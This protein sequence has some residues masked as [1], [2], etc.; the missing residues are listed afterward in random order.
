MNRRIA[1]SAGPRRDGATYPTSPADAAGQPG[2]PCE[3]ATSTA[4][5]HGA[6]PPPAG[7]LTHAQAACP[8]SPA[9][10]LA[11]AA[12]ASGPSW[13]LRVQGAGRG[14]TLAAVGY[15]NPSDRSQPLRP[16]YVTAARAR[17]GILASWSTSPAF[18]AGRIIGPILE[19]TRSTPA[20]KYGLS[21]R[22]I[23]LGSPSPRQGQDREQ[24]G[25][26]A[27]TDRM[28]VCAHDGTVVIRNRPRARGTCER[29][30]ASAAR[31]SAAAD[32][33]NA[34]PRFSS[35]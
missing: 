2:E 35:G 1:T 31:T 33:E 22:G 15:P 8:P 24:T 25:T 9:E 29:M 14:G 10:P 27:V 20:A 32:V 5:V 6:I 12:A 17:R 28:P 30:V 11:G 16:D 23:G 34:P 18:S 3:C 13:H 4:G 7:S 21:R 19:S 26:N